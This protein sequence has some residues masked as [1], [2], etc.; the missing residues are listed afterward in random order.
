[1]EEK[2]EAKKVRSHPSGT[3]KQIVRDRGY[4]RQSNWG[5]GTLGDCTPFIYTGVITVY[6]AHRRHKTRRRKGIFLRT[7]A[8]LPKRDS[9][10]APRRHYQRRPS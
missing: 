3:T 10:K 6:A 4:H 5:R 8:S 2:L 1:M 7:L 9:S